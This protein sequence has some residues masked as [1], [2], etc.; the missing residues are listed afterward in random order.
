MSRH[1]SSQSVTLDHNL[2]LRILIPLVG[3]IMILIGCGLWGLY[4]QAQQSIKADVQSRV[5]G[6]NRVLNS[7]LTEDAAMIR[8]FQHFISSEKQL[9]QAWLAR[10]REALLQHATPVYEKLN[11]SN[12]ITHFYFIDLDQTCYLRV[13]SPSRAGDTIR[14]KTMQQAASTGK[15]SYGIEL[16]KFGHFTLRVVQPWFIKGEHVGYIELG[17]EIEHITPKL[18][19]ILEVEAVFAI[20][21]EYLQRE[22]WQEGLAILNRTG[23]WDQLNNYVII[24]QTLPQLPDDLLPL[25]DSGTTSQA[26]FSVTDDTTDIE[27]CAGILPL[28]D[29]SQQRVGSLI[30]LE[31][32]TQ[33]SAYLSEMAGTLLLVGLATG[34]CLFVICYFYLTSLRKT[35]RQLVQSAHL[36]GKAEIATSILHNVGNVLNSVNVSAGLIQEKVSQSSV[37]DLMKAIDIIEEHVAD[38]GNYVTEDDRGKHLPAFLIDVGHQLSSEEE[39]ILEEV[40]ALV[41]NIEHI[42]SV[43]A[44]QQKHAVTDMDLIEEFSLS[45]LLEDAISINIAS[46]ERHAIHI[47]REYENIGPLVSNKQL[48]LQL[49]INLISN[50]KYACIE[51]GHTNH[52]LTIRTQRKAPDKI[53]IQIQ[54]N[55]QG[56]AAENLVRIFAHGFTTRAEGHGFGLH[57]AALAAAELGGKLVATSNGPGTGATFTLEI[58]YHKAGAPQCET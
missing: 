20:A 57:S 2:K 19:E 35:S 16:G 38:L 58:P 42:K 12:R 1:R 49:L 13:H 10:D 43:V 45:Q 29:A 22:Q 31:D 41:R 14:R 33:Q 40:T 39:L 27:Y 51:S 9:Q 53:V 56:I 26:E 7:Q 4:G 55:G 28:K 8:G 11:A 34:S 54:D 46:M 30:I 6:A 37:P 17:E 25:I 23:D 36:A 48:L 44:S 50:A 52:Q 47:T 5:Q 21:K 24:D 3:A 32:I 18:T 15:T